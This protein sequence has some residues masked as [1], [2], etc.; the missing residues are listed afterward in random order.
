MK[1]MGGVVTGGENPSGG[2]RVRW[3]VAHKKDVGREL[4]WIT[5]E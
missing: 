4:D 2:K 5:E 1:G 3:R